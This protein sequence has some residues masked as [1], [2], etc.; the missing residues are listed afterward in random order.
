MDARRTHAA[1]RRWP[2]LEGPD[3][4][5][6][7]A[8]DRLLLDEAEPHLPDPAHT[9]ADS[10]EARSAVVVIGD[11]YGGI[12][13]PLLASDAVER[14][15]FHTDNLLGER[16]LVANLE[17]LGIERERAAIHP[18]LT[19]DLVAGARL[20]LLRMPRSLD[21]LRE[22]AE[23]VA[24]HADQ[25][26]R[27]IGAGRDKYLTRAMNDVLADSFGTVTASRGRQ[28]S[29]ALHAVGARP[30]VAPSFPQ[31]ARLTEPGLEVDVV[32]HG[33]AFAGA[34]LD[35]GT[36]VLLR[37][38]GAMAPG[39]REAIDLGCGTGVL[40]VALALSRPELR[41][42]AIDVSAAAVASA[43]GAAGAN[44]VAERVRVQR[45]DGL[46]ETGDASADLI[47]CNP[48]MHVASSLV[49]DAGARLLRGAGRVLRPGGELWT[50]YNSRLSRAKELRRLV[51]PTEVVDDDGRFTVA[52]TVGRG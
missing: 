38:L 33:G 10:P 6:A 3:L 9:G 16:A 41:T 21:A 17:R 29:R 24:R 27:L 26:V 39:A 37:H 14:V 15:R 18:A 30:G 11:L 8:A 7:D 31:R 47:V 51:G 40:A 28:K 2:D 42:T 4:P 43:R 45:A 22:I 32:A 34:R 44:G 5:A 35:V 19:P 50:V 13:A 1:L 20:V 25:S 12:T 48:P 49:P 36:R 23:L 46:N 52:R